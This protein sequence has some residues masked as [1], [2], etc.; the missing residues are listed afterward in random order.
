MQANRYPGTC[1]A[2]GRSVDA[3]KGIIERHGR[4]WLVWCETCYNASDH[5]GAEDRACGDRAY[6]DQC[7]ARCGL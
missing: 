1:G 6:E 3:G 2:C 4:R 7:A 5:S